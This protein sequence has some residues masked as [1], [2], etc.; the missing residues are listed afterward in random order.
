MMH[1]GVSGFIQNPSCSTVTAIGAFSTPD[2]NFVRL[3]TNFVNLPPD[4]I[5]ALVPGLAAT[6]VQKFRTDIITGTLPL[7]AIESNCAVRCGL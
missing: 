1:A 3:S 2:P 4:L 6:D 5:A 7:F